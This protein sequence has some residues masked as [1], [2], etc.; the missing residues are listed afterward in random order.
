MPAH[1]PDTA[2]PDD[3][4]IRAASRLTGAAATK[5]PAGRAA[6][7]LV[8][9]HAL[10]SSP[11]TAADAL[12]LLHELQVHQVEL[13]LQAQELQDSRDELESALRRQIE[14]YDCQP[15]ACFT[16]DARLVVHEL[17]LAGASLLRL[18]REEA[19]GLGLDSFVAA[20]SRPRLK[21]L[22]S[23]APMA[24]QEPA[25]LLQ[26]CHR[27]GSEQP[28]WAHIGADPAGHHFFVAFAAAGAVTQSPPSAV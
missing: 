2:C 23:S 27:D 7:A 3:L 20:A 21:E 28:V 10:A 18:A 16:I 17:N 15:V 13:D 25:C 1:T 6:D 11:A 8:V 14:L 5:G 9:L 19:Y 26:L 4:R 24:G 22:L 12:T